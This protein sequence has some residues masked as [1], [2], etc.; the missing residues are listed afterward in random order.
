MPIIEF[1]KVCKAYVKDTAVIKDL[2]LIVDEGEFLILL[3]ESG[4]GKTTILKM[5]NRMTDF[6]TGWI[7]F[8]GRPISDW[9]KVE[10]RRSI[11]YVIQQIGLFP[12]MNIRDNITYVPDIM[13]QEREKSRK[14]AA[15]LIKL[16]GLKEADLDKYPR[17]MSG[18]QKQR[19]GVARALAGDPSIILMDEPFGAVD[20]VT[21]TQLQ[22]EM[23]KIHRDLKKT[24]I[25]VTHDIHEAVKLGTRIILINNGKIEQSGKPI[26]LVLKPAND[27][28]KNFFGSKGFA[29]IIDEEVVDDL[30]KRVLD[31]SLTLDELYGMLRA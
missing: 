1:E 31:G 16:V 6:D 22:E 27:F 8:K 3:G 18:G 9:D 21:R 2:D 19:V 13:K 28:V 5:I 17:E 30:Y 12:H 25:F 7:R 4:C 15:E 23:L 11:G 29:S 26:E 10:L 20:G 14:R 24:I